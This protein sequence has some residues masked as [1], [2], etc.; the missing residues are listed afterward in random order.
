MVMKSKT[1]RGGA[2]QLL[3]GEVFIILL[4]PPV[5]TSQYFIAADMVMKSK[6]LVGEVF[7]ILL[8][9]PHLIIPPHHARVYMFT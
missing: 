7:T 8:T 5:I 2:S 6:V 1:L 9:S 3:F 4:T